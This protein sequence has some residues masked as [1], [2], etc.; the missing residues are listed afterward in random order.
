M[1]PIC[2]GLI[3]RQATKEPYYLGFRS[4]RCRVVP[5]N[6]ETFQGFTVI[7][8]VR[9]YGVVSWNTFRQT[10]VVPEKMP[11]ATEHN[12]YEWIPGT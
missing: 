10:P 5:G 3:S 1:K 7:G 6:G 4:V 8:D 12:C 9:F 2:N 11:D